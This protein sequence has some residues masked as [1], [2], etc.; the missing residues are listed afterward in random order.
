M[1]SVDNTRPLVIFGMGEDAELALYYFENDTDRNV[2]AFCVDPGYVSKDSWHGRRVI[3][4]DKVN[5][6]FGPDTFDGFVAV[7]YSGLNKLRMD[8]C[9]E[10]IAKG[11]KLASYV[12]SH[13]TVFSDLDI[14]WNA[15]LLEHNTVQPYVKIG[16]GV[17]LWSGNHIGHHT[18]IEDFVF[19]ASQVV[20][21]GC[22]MIGERSFL[23][24]N[25]TI[26]NHISIGSRCVI[27]AGSLVLGDIADES[28]LSAEPAKL[29]RV[30]SSRLRNI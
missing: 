2:A 10:F 18:R 27:G 11:Y 21:S 26:R 19:V 5:E 29:S 16:N 3:P 1:H 6:T 12:S 17:T 13:A 14:G 9:N 25:A 30:P 23:G 4:F 7:G 28:V 22:V 20:V 15:F 8:R 24:V